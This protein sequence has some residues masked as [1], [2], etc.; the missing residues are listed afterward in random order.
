MSTRC[1][2]STHLFLP[3]SLPHQDGRHIHQFIPSEAPFFNVSHTIQH[4]SFGDEYPGRVNPL[5]G[6]VKVRGESR[7][8]G[9]V[10]A[11]RG[12]SLG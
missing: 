10:K 1:I 7:R 6:K 8:G 11:E 9:G 4:V 5:D 2:G 3:P 12:M